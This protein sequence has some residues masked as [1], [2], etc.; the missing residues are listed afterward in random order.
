MPSRYHQLPQQFNSCVT[1]RKLLPLHKVLQIEKT[2]QLQTVKQFYHK[3]KITQLLGRG[4]YGAVYLSVH[5]STRTLRAVKILSNVKESKISFCPRRQRPVPNEVL[6]QEPLC[7]PNIVKLLEVYLDKETETWYLVQ[8]YHPGFTDLFS[9]INNSGPLTTRASS[10]IINQLVCVLQ[11][12]LNEC[13]ID[14][15]DVKDENILYNPET[16]QIKLIDFGSAG[17]L[18]PGPYTGFYCHLIKF[19]C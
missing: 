11:H 18:S 15:R 2:M 16:G 10:H 13:G 17:R 14:H 6:L 8:E 12:L 19:L 3:Y 5:I 9:H 1:Q 4:G 7:H